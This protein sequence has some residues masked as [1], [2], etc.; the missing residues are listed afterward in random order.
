MG[1]WEFPPKAT[2]QVAGKMEVPGVYLQTMNM[3]QI[4]ERLK[5]NDLII[6]PVGSTECHGAAQPI[7]EDTFLVTRMAEQVA[8]ATG[9]TIAMPIWYGSHPYNHL[10]MPGTVV[11]P[12]EVFLANLRAVIAG[13]WNMGFRKQIFLNGHGQEEVIPNALHQWAKKYQVP[14]VLISLHWETVI[15]QH[16]KDKAHG[17]PFETKFQHADEAECSYSLALFPEFCDMT[18]AEDNTGAGYLP[19]GDIKV[20]SLEFASHVDGGGEVYHNPIKGHE[21]VGLS[22]IELSVYPKGVI[23]RP[24]LASAEKAIPGL[25]D[26]LDYMVKLVGDIMT[27][28]PAGTLPPTEQVT[29]RDPKEVEAL[30]KGPLK[31]GKHIYTVA[32]PP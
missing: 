17:G 21:H 4:N 16:L 11:V 31:G 6:I 14:S 12:E 1:K 3:T 15:H 30:L 9:C 29:Q 27:K 10:G 18:K 24:T 13:L 7:G 22:G 5:T 25:N 19:A 32:Y 8:A 23:G 26:L 2:N 28:F 20:G